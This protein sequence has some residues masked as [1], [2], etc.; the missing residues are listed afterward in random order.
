[1]LIKAPDVS[2][3]HHVSSPTTELLSRGRLNL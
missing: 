1:M 2:L 3:Q